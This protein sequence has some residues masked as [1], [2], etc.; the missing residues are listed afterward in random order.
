MPCVVCLGMVHAGANMLPRTVKEVYFI[1][2]SMLFGAILNAV[3]FGQVRQSP[4]HPLTPSLMGPRKAAGAHSMETT[5]GLPCQ[6]Q[7]CRSPEYSQGWLWRAAE[8]PAVVLAAAAC[9]V[10]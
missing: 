5:G 7:Q 4:H 2:V 6:R 9:L 10:R 3:L 8:L 1:I